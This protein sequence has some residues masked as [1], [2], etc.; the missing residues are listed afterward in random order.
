MQQKNHQQY[1]RWIIN[2]DFGYKENDPRDMPLDLQVGDLFQMKYHTV[3]GIFKDGRTTELSREAG[4]I[5]LIK[6]VIRQGW[7]RKKIVSIETLEED[8]RI[9]VI[10][11]DLAALFFQNDVVERIQ[12]ARQSPSAS[13]LFQTLRQSLTKIWTKVRR[14]LTMRL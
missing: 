13:H 3:A 1:W 5:I 9:C 11:A 6:K 8:G 12:R 2:T 10:S 7:Y 14:S 4:K